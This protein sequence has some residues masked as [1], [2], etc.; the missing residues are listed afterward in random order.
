MRYKIIF[1]S[2]LVF[3]LIGCS[4]INMTRQDMLTTTGALIGIGI[5]MKNNISN[6]PSS[7]SSHN[8]TTH[9]AG[10]NGGFGVAWILGGVL[11]GIFGLGVDKALEHTNYTITIEDN[12]N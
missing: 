7:S 6:T 12:N 10:S 5:A 2:C 4:N 9:T 11:G 8:T 1:I 3:S